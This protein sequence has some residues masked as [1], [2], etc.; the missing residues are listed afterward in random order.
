MESPINIKRIKEAQEQSEFIKSCE[1]RGELVWHKVQE[2]FL[3]CDQKDRVII[4]LEIATYILNELHNWLQHPGINTMFSSINNFFKIYK[5]KTRIK[6]IVNNC[7]SCAQEKSHR[8]IYGKIHGFAYSNER[9]KFIALDLM[10]PF[11]M[12]E[13]KSQIDN[14]T[15]PFNLLTII[16]IN[17]NFFK[18]AL[19]RRT[20]I[21]DILK[22][23]NKKW[24]T[25]FEKPTKFL[26]TMENSLF[27]QS[28]HRN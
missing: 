26:Q 17:S 8:A 23:L 3:A 2:I 11:E 13:F 7:F 9:W 16:N 25:L 27:P 10:G 21:T 28:S 24:L 4:P 15:N 6:E 14:N 22:A 20:R 19:L 12:N 5:L 1:E 18:V